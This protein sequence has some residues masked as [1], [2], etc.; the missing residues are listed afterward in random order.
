MPRHCLSLLKHRS[1]LFRSLYN[2]G[3]KATGLPPALPLRRRAAVWS[4]FS[5][6]T[7][8]ILRLRR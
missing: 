6:I 2:S 3:S 7:A 5:G 8:V 1:T 4:T